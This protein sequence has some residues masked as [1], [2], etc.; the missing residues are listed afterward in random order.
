L[1]QVI[2]L[3]KQFRDVV[4]LDGVDLSVQQ[5]RIHGLIGPNGSGKSTLLKA[6]VGEHQPTSGQIMFAGRDIT[7]APP[8]ERAR[9]GMVIKFQVT[10]IVRELTTFDNLLLSLQ[11]EQSP[12]SLFRSRSKRSLRDDVWHMLHQFHL[13]ERA[14]ERAGNLS[15]GEQ[16]WLEIA[17][18]VARRPRLL[19][20]DEPTAGM[21]PEE[22]RMTGALLS[23]LR[24]QMS[25]VIVEHDLDFIKGLC[26]II[27]VLHQGRVLDEGT[28]DEIEESEMV[29]S[30]YITRS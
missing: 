24:D 3:R 18:A 2:D 6:V 19:L 17:M 12:W 9:H 1:L 8:H 15:H 10:S 23:I 26:D 14:S 16:Q 4:A 13:A 27:T 25:I 5:R 30:A 7:S 28:P 21:S 20:L 22:R 29:K 11:V